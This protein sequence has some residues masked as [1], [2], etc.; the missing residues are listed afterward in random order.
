MKTLITK[1]IKNIKIN[2]QE[3]IFDFTNDSKKI[4]RNITLNKK[5]SLNIYWLLYTNIDYELNIIC[6]LDSN[7]NFIFLLLSDLRNKIKLKIN[8]EIKKSNCNVNIKTI[9]MIQNFWEINVN[10][11]IK[12]NKWIK[13]ICANN[14]FENIFLWNDGQINSCPSLEV[15]SQDAKTSHSLK[16]EKISDKKLFYLQSRWIDKKNATAIMLKS[17]IYNNFK[18][19]RNKNID[20][21]DKKILEIYKNFLKVK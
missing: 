9:S 4:K 21:F 1:S 5:S 8:V 12:I 14:I 7:L 15:L 13:N 19:L 3:Y 11:N 6:D 10:W 20:I 18:E 2:K 17:L 16:I